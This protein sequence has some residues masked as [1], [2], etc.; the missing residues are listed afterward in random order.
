MNALLESKSQKEK[1]L[2]ILTMIANDKNKSV[3]A[4]ETLYQEVNDECHL[5]QYELEKVLNNHQDLNRK[6]ECIQNQIEIMKMGG[7]FS[8]WPNPILHSNQ[9]KKEG[10]HNVIVIKPC[11]YC[12]KWYLAKDIVIISCEHTFHPFCLV[13]MLEHP[14]KC[15]L[16]KQKLHPKWWNSWGF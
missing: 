2:E 4:S 5:I 14:N 16:C 1:E 12:N 3:V 6:K 8:F 11:G 13:T 15:C 9:P 10:G 7:G